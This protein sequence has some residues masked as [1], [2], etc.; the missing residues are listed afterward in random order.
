MKTLSLKTSF[1]GAQPWV[2]HWIK[3]ARTDIVAMFL[4]RRGIQTSV[5][6]EIKLRSNGK[7]VRAVF[8]RS[9][10]LTQNDS[11]CSSIPVDIFKVD[12]FLCYERIFLPFQINRLSIRDS[13]GF[14]FN[15]LYE[16]NCILRK[17]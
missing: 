6:S 17:V 16:S 12:W 11:E 3:T 1:S 5:K 13:L 2:M 7:S 9:T 8:M 4:T 15:P 10:T 14:K